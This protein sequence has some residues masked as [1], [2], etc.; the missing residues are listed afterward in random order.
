MAENSIMLHGGALTAEL[1]AQI[2]NGTVHILNGGWGGAVTSLFTDS[3]AVTGDSMFVCISGENFDGHN[4]AASAVTS[5]ARIILAERVPD[6]EISTGVDVVIVDDTIKALGR[7]AG[8]YIKESGAETIA[9]TGSVGKTTTKEFIASC[10]AVKHRVH[11]TEGNKNN[12]IGLPLTALSMEA[13]TEYAVFECGMSGMHEIEYL[14]RIV[15]PDV[16][17]ITNIGTAHIEKLGS[18][19]NIAKAKLE[20]VSG[21]DPVTGVLIINADEPLLYEVKDSLPVGKVITAAQHNREADFRAVN[22]R[23]TGNGMVFDLIYMGKVATNIEIPTIGVHNVYDALYAFAAGIVC[24]LSEA[25]IRAGLKSFRGVAM[26]QKIYELAG[27][28]VIED[29]Y[30]AS[31]ESMR[32]SIDVLMS[33]AKEKGGR[34]AALLGDMREL[35]EYSRLLHEQLGVYAAR[36]GLQLLFTYGAIA[37]NIATAAISNGVRAENVYVNVDCGNPAPTGDMVLG[38]LEAGDV[39]L[40]KASRAV[41]AEAVLEY[42][43]QKVSDRT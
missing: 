40:V 27:F 13:D 12:E 29:C 14:S 37:E 25:E 1:T 21:M 2:T 22:L 24:G 9:V 10:F 11:K 41:A 32:A 31:P 20:I 38:A 39:L 34:A 4:Y 15:K 18:R 17:V 30:N 33:V 26:R 36:A 5:G 6:G 3:R 28:T 16:A 35:G 43:K 19:E 8:Y 23:R 7:L 42:I